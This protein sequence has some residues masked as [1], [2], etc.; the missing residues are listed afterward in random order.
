MSKEPL[1]LMSDDTSRYYKACAIARESGFDQVWHA[2]VPTGRL[3][4]W[5]R[6]AVVLL[7]QQL[8]DGVEIFTNQET[9]RD[10]AGIAEWLN[11]C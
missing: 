7:I 4:C 10:F 9:P 5:S 11:P 2:E 3:S 8:G 1:S 6:H